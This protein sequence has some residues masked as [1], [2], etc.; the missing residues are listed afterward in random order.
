MMGSLTFGESEKAQKVDPEDD[1]VEEQL[2][3][4]A[5][6]DPDGLVDLHDGVQNRTL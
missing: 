3:G 6:G 1:H 5:G 4:E 2:H